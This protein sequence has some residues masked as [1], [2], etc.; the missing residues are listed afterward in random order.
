MH[1][2]VDNRETDSGAGAAT[3]QD[4]LQT[5]MKRTRNENRI[6]WSVQLNGSAYSETTP[7]EAAQVN[8]ADIQTLAIETRSAEDIC[9]DFIRHS[10]AIASGL[11]KGADTASLLF[12]T[13]D[14][15][16]AN[17]HYGMLLDSC[18]G[19]FSLLHESEMILMS[20]ESD[21]EDF[22]RSRKETV[23]RS[24]G[25][26]DSMMA[27]QQN[28]DWTVLADV[29]EYELAPLLRRYKDVVEAQAA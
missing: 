4:I 14:H 7:H 24:F 5:I 29:L 13:Q 28:E 1:L 11:L 23:Q 16:E 9:R 10:G 15:H 12:R 25:V 2:T 18:H 17:R 27:A 26:F 19:F 3:L 8:A 6:I 22:S 21:S 20:E